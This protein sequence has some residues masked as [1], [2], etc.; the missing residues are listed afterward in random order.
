[1]T[2]DKQQQLIRDLILESTEAL[3]QFEK[4]LLLLEKKEADPD[5]PHRIFRAIH[6]LKGTSGC[7]ALHKIEQLAHSGENVLSLMRDGKLQP[8]K[9]VVS[10]LFAFSDGLRKTLA[11]V[12]QTGQEGAADHSSLIAD[13]EALHRAASEQ[14]SATSTAGACGLFTDDDPSAPAPAAAPADA[15]AIAESAIR[16]DVEQLDRIMDLVG[17]LVLARN[18]IVRF[19]GSTQ[20]PELVKPTQRLNLITSKLQ[21]NIMKTRMQPIGNLWNK[22]P[23]VV[24]D[25]ALGLGKQVALTMEGAETELDRTILEAIKDPLTHLVRNSI[26]HGLETPEKRLAAGK[27]AESVLKLRAL[28]E[29]G[30]VIIQVF[31]DGAGIDREKVLRKAVHR[32]LIGAEDV[33]RLSEREV[34]ALLFQ[35]GF[36]TAEKITNLSGRGVGMDVVKRNIERI[37]GSVDIQ[38]EVGRSTTIRIK[39]PLTLAIVPALIVTCAGVRYAIPQA[40][41][42]E[43]VRIGEDETA[44]VIE[45]VGQSPVYRL[46]GH[47]LPLVHLR[48]QL[49]L[50]SAAQGSVFLVVVQAEGRQ[51]GLVVDSILDTEEIVVKPLGKELK[52]LSVYAG[53]TIMGDGRVA[54]ILD[55]I[56]IARRVGLLDEN[57]NKLS[58]ATAAE[59]RGAVRS[60]RQSLLLVG[61]GKGRQ[62]AIP[63]SSVARLEEFALASVEHAGESEVVQYRGE[64]MPLVDIPA[65]LGY[66]ADDGE[67]RRVVVYALDGRSY[68]LI[69][70]RIL[71][72]L[73]CEAKLQHSTAR[74]GILGSAVVQKRVTDF[75]DIP[76]LVASRVSK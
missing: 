28:H 51:F 12:S 27:P 5:A 53:A 35:P 25:M 56:G 68:G 65:A 59:S 46:R 62:A 48:D 23:R 63:L 13:L 49:K 43:L 10:K 69:V 55:I 41:I 36:S 37:G 72:I 31:D 67:S 14:Q 33:S 30:Q 22:F 29:G 66:G 9:E 2:S 15:A 71:D 52:G 1:M 50:A 34:Y 74:T 26:D 6:S 57:S 11:E 58:A 60:E 24:R 32:N 7:L 17:E 44:R 45:Y 19:A 38:S 70:E 18:Q 73:D 61:L 21:E 42:V 76:A 54:L 3:D 8:E 75:L 20:D 64:I 47:L 4:D 40:S 39:I 16:V